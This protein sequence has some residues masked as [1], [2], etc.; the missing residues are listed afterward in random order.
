[1]EQYERSELNLEMYEE[2]DEDL[3]SHDLY[4]YPT[5]KFKARYSESHAGTYA[6]IFGVAAALGAIFLFYDRNLSKRK[7]IWAFLSRCFCYTCLFP[8]QHQPKI[9]KSQFH[10]IFLHS[11][12]SVCGSGIEAET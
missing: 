1:M 6:A 8:Q 9:P 11:E 5:E 2:I 7:L 4:L 10:D 12:I 3:C